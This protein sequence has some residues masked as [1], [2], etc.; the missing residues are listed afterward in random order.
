MGRFFVFC[1]FL[2]WWSQDLDLFIIEEKWEKK[3]K[4]ERKRELKGELHI[5]WIVCDEDYKGSPALVSLWNVSKYK[6]SN[7]PLHYLL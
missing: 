6:K 2:Q 3:E 5:G 1:F 4:K 7:I